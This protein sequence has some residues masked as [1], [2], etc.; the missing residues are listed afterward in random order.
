[1][2][3]HVWPKL[4]SHA[5]TELAQNFGIVYNAHNALDDALTC[6]KLVQM[7]AGEFNPSKKIDD[8]LENMGVEIKCLG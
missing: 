8:F 2:A 4:E 1:L 3:R 7:A 5:L 6:G